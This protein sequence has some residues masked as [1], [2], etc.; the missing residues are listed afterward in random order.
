VPGTVEKNDK[1]S[2]FPCVSLNLSSLSY[3]HFRGSFMS[4]V[5]FRVSYTVADENRSSYLGAV[6]SLRQHYSSTDVLFAVFETQQ[7][8]G[9]FE[10]VYIY[11]SEAAYDASDDPSSF[12]EATLALIEQVSSLATNVRYSVAR[13]V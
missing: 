12:G 7:K 6:S 2:A 10:E 9:H 8:S 13:E 4:R 3:L 11:P 1:S 5:L